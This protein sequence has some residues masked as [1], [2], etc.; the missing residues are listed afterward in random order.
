MNNKIDLKILQE[1]IT[2]LKN[3]PNACTTFEGAKELMTH[4]LFWNLIQANN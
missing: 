4:L 2:D 3:N 1:T